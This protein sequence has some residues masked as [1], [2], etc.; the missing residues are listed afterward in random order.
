MTWCQVE[1]RGMTWC[2]VQPCGAAWSHVEP[3][4][5]T[6][7]QVQPC[8]AAWS[9]VVPGGARWSRVVPGGT[10]WCCCME[11]RGACRI[12]QWT[13]QPH[14]SVCEMRL[15]NQ[16]GHG[17]VISL[18]AAGAP[19]RFTPS[20]RSLVYIRLIVVIISASPPFVMSTSGHHLGGLV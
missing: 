13:L 1:P 9:H 18:H 17:L 16:Q 5:A 8:G 10:R 3:R 14:S 12:F 7:C 4:G 20:Y 6:W 15:S 19:G 11:P 2:Q